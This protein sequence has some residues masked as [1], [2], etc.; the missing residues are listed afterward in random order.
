MYYKNKLKNYYV[1]LSNGNDWEK[2]QNGEPL[3]KYSSY[4]NGE[5]I[6]FNLT[7]I[8][9]TILR[10]QETLLLTTMFIMKGR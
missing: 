6:I 4:S 2:I 1:N 5:V 3:E 10:L 7:L 8:L 9:K